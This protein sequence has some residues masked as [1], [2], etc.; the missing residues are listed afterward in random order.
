MNREVSRVKT[1]AWI[2]ATSNSRKV[3]KIP[4]ATERKWL[5]TQKQE[6]PVRK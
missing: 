3:I 2:S 6:K 1:Y 4:N 5:H